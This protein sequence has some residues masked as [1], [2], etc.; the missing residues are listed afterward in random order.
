MA[1][2]YNQATLSYNGNLINSNITTGEI[3]ATLSM[4]KTAVTSTYDGGDNI[5]YIVNIV[6]SG[7]APFT[8]LT[9]TDNLGSYTLG[10]TTNIVPLTYRENSVRYFVNG[11]LQATPTVAATTP[12]TITGINVP[13]NSNATIVYETDVNSYAPLAAG[14]RIRNIASITGAGVADPVTDDEVIIAAA[15]PNLSIVKALSP[16]TVNENGLVTYTITVQ[17]TGN[18]ATSASDNIFITDTFTPVLSDITVT[19]NGETLPASSYSYNETT[20]L[21]TTAAGVVSVPAATFTQNPATGV[22]TVNPGTA[23]LTVTG[24]I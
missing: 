6:N 5:T 20:G 11:E 1:S 18:T 21:F 22:W 13:A 2:F 15:R 7:T 14:S 16:T 4:T 12:L 23:V 9:L 8:G 3:V 17:N 19:L 10:S 24:R